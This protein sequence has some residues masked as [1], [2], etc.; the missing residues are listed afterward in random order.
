M[1]NK[2]FI[3]DVMGY[4]FRSFHAIR[5]MSTSKGEPTNALFGFARSFINL[6]K[7][8]NP[9][10]VVAV[11]DGENNERSRKEL[12]AEYKAHRSKA[13]D[14]L[15]PQ[16]ATVEEFLELNGI[17]MVSLEG[18]EADD[19]MASIARLFE[20]QGF[21]VYLCS[22]DKDLAQLVNPQI[23]MLNT[24][25]DN[26][27]V[28]EAGV[29]E[30]F[31]VP[32]HQ[33]RDY[34]AIVGDASDNVPGVS[35][36]GPKGAA[37]LLKQYGSLEAILENADQIKGKKGESLKTH[38]EDA[39]LS[40]KLVTLDEAL[41]IPQ[42]P[43]FYIPKPQDQKKLL[44]FLQE[45]EFNTLAQELSSVTKKETKGEYHLVNTP[46]AIQELVAQLEK[47]PFFCIDAETTSEDPMRAELV[48]FGVGFEEGKAYYLPMYPDLLPLFKPLLQ[49]KPVY[50]HNIKYDMHVFRRGGMPLHHIIFDT[51]VASY[52]IQADERQHSLDRLAFKEFE[53]VK[54]P[55]EDLIGKGKKQITMREV[56]LDKITE[57]CCEDID[58]T[59]RLKN[60]YEKQLHDRK[61]DK[62]FKEIELPLIDVLAK[63]EARG[64]FVDTKVLRPL[65][66]KIQKDL[67][68][69][70][71]EIYKLAGEEF[72]LN[73]PKQLSEI[74]FTKLNIRAPKKTAT[75]FST[76][77]DVL[78]SL[79][80]EYPIA[81][82]ILEYRSL[83]KLRSTYIDTLPEQ[84]HPETGRIHCT[85]NQ[86]VAATGRLASQNPNLQNIPVRTELGREI[87][88][89]FRPQKPGWSYVAGDYSQIELRLLAH[90]S[91]DPKLVEIFKQGKDIHAATAA[92][93]FGVSQEEVTPE[94]RYRAKAVNFG[95]I[96][97]Q[98]AWGLS[99]ELKIEPKV[100]GEFIEKYFHNYPGVK[101]YLEKMKQEARETKV[102]KTLMGRERRLPDITASNP[103]IR[104]AQERLAVNTP[105]QGTNADLIKLAMIQL[106]EKIEKLSLKGY[107]ILQIHDELIFEVP[108]EEVPVFEKLVKETLEGVATLNVPLVVNIGVGKNWK[109]C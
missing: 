50:G 96:Y 42:D 52:L 105:L 49:K 43:T 24:F 53:K 55:I 99:Q 6:Q 47:Q 86:S 33:I 48:G 103:M 95:I 34:L 60:L 35:G 68:H 44:H 45:K 74:L 90:F 76:N 69:L 18:V 19:S 21:E 81:E 27:I 5:H 4:I 15:V 67:H 8:F 16:F 22:T 30:N 14:E 102:T 83:E 37:E 101:N 54:I 61:L 79:A 77:A 85:F 11:F 92:S 62:L 89:A 1:T 36:I 109:E 87:R 57:Y 94:M 25:K 93:I 70:Q 63:M 7:T 91:L 64:V 106:E 82:L 59:I 73:S 104:Q 108:D 41:P 26:L 29:L 46:E 72:N 17:P 31:G 56:P 58:Y 97:G 65:S 80:L 3:I 38:R 12:Y 71:T 10:Y 13:P 88:A 20:K 75:G 84:I 2:I 40:R 39:L 28:D 51:M 32:P 66:E 98:Q 100:A 23:K 9:E 78:E 107:M